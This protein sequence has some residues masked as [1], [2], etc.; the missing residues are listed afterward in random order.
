ME[1]LR[2]GYAGAPVVVFPTSGGNHHEFAERGMLE[3]LAKKIDQGIIQ[4]FC[5]DTNNWEGWYNEH[6]H[7]R[8][9]VE[10]SVAF[11]EYLIHEF[12]PHIREITGTDVLVLTGISFGA[13]HAM[14]FALKHPELVNRAVT[15]SGS[16]SIKSFLVDYYDDLCYFNN[17]VDYIQNLT[18][19]WF[20]Q[21]YNEHTELLLVTSDQD[22][23]LDKNLEMVHHLTA[24]G[25]R[26][27]FVKWEGDFKH[28][29]PYWKQMI[30]HY[31]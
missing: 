6:I 4:V 5:V 3:P 15:F 22:V 14:N 2:F 13:Y 31:I 10:R 17:P 18:D 16:F 1:F 29:W 9:K 7:P 20:L 12:L 8:L 30:G 19:P 24:K 28:D 25:I 11:E 23:C 26:H 27:T 21:Q